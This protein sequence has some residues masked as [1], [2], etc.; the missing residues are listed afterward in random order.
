MNPMS[1]DSRCPAQWLS[2]AAPLALLAGCA[3]ASG[4]S[5]PQPA[6]AP[7]SPVSAAAVVDAAAQRGM[8]ASIDP[9]LAIFRD[10]S[11]AK[12]FAESYLAET[13][14]EP[15]ITVEEQDAILEM[16]ELIAADKIDEAMRLVEANRGPASSAL[17]DFTAGNLHY[18]KDEFPQ[19]AVAYRAAVDKFP[20]F[21]RAWQM[22]GEACFRQNDAANAAAAFTRV[23]VLGGG[24]AVTYGLVGINHARLGNHVGAEFAFRIAG[25]LD[26][27]KVE[28]KIGLV[29]SYYEQGRFAEAATL[30]DTLIASEPDRAE[31]WLEQGKAWARLGQPLKAAQNFEMVD[32]LGAST[33]ASLSNLGNIYAN[34]HLFELAVDAYRRA[35]RLDPAAATGSALRAAKYLSESNALA[36]LRALVEGIESA[37]GGT[38]DEPAR[39]DLLKLRARLAVAAGADEEG[40]RVLQEIVDLDPLDGDA[41]ILL[42]RHFGR[43]GDEERAILHFERAASLEAFEAE[44]KLRHGEL[45]VKQGKYPQALPLLRRAQALKP[46]E[47][48]RKYIEQVERAVR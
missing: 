22:L 12:R 6:A 40:A 9:E 5:E 34:E 38:L 36:E 17:L 1:V 29:R 41:L 45:L 43:T 11:Y 31:L 21:R 37:A 42:G 14:I 28:W 4:A 3:V 18:Q 10:P 30:F 46:R 7:A 27:E 25:M 47:H 15:A 13:E 44:A 32:R 23:I 19:A 33:V 16:R 39:K 8:D 24:D 48:V 26:P 2:W 20:K 35:L